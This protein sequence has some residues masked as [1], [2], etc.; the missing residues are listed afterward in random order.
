MAAAGMTS[1][2]AAIVPNRTNLFGIFTM[3]PMGHHI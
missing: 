3:S 2:A 1:A